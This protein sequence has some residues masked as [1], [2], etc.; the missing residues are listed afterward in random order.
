[1]DSMRSLDKSLPKSLNPRSAQPPG[2]LLQ[3]FRSAALSV[4]NL[5][6]TAAAEQSKARLSGY[7]EALDSLLAFLDKENLGLG[8]GE[9]WKVRKWATERLDGSPIAPTGSDS[10]EDRGETTKRARSSSPVLQRKSSH[11]TLETRLPSRSNSPVGTTRNPSIPPTSSLQPVVYTSASDVFSF[12]SPHPYPQDIDMQ[13]DPAASTPSHLEPPLQESGSISAPPSR[14]EFLP[15]CSRTSQRSGNHM[16]RH[17]TRSTT[18]VRSLGTG[19]GSK[20]KIAFNEYFDLG[21]LGD[22]KDGIGGA[23]RGK[24]I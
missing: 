7:Q 13:P 5:Y 21:N 1:M 16:N 19:A 8:D 20:R 14:L 17:N 6:K 2:Q 18:S 24:F 12:R 10:D 9:G 11:E 15:R 23:K 3:S 4:T 22:G